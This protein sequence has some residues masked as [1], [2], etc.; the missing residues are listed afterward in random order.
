MN[1]MKPLRTLLSIK[2]LNVMQSTL[3]ELQPFAKPI[4]PPI[5]AARLGKAPIMSAGLHA[6]AMQLQGATARL[7]GQN[8]SYEALT[9]LPTQKI[10]NRWRTS[11]LRRDTDEQPVT[12]RSSDP[13]F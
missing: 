2:G 12:A 13:P 1:R 3:R 10:K 9:F 6:P 11:L 8:S 5:S 4:I 7:V